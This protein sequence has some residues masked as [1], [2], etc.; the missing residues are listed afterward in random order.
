MGALHVPAGSVVL[1][2]LDPGAVEDVVVLEDV[3]V[4]E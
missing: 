2:V 3:D 1:V 4:V